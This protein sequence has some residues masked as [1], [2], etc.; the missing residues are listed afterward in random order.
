MPDLNDDDGADAGAAFI[1]V[2][3]ADGT[4]SEQAELHPAVPVSSGH[5]GSAVAIDGDTVIVGAN[6][7][8]ASKPGRAYIFTRS[9]TTWTEEFA[10]SPT[11]PGSENAH[12]GNSVD[13]DGDTAI[14]GSASIYTG[15][16][17]LADDG[18]G[19]AEQ[20]VLEPTSDLS[21]TY[22]DVDGDRVAVAT[23]GDSF[24][25]ASGAGSITTYTRSGTTWTEEQ[26]L[27]AS[28]ATANQNLGW[29]LE[30]EG[31]RLV[32]GAPNNGS[33]NLGALYTFA[34][35]GGTWSQESKVEIADLGPGEKLGRGLGLNGD[36]LVAGAPQSDVWGNL[37]GS[38][39]YLE[40]SGSTWS[41]ARRLTARRTCRRA[42]ATPCRSRERPPC[43]WWLATSRSTT[44]HPAAQP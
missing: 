27:G 41:R 4:W 18:A 16:F 21:P 28:D 19:W 29:D 34:F 26:E 22:V 1:F 44:S 7:S 39:A 23:I 8:G 30:L 13:I 36:R 32:A 15:A 43:R 12:I 37:S 3:A 17:V 6:E 5:F 31:D 20:A 33:S 38:V 11:N 35:S 2:R 10:F 24:G 40:R 42:S 9:G 25:G 14:V